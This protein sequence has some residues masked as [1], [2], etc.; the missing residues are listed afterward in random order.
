MTNLERNSIRR[1]NLSK[2]LPS[3]PLL[4]TKDIPPPSEFMLGN[5]LNDRIDANETSQKILHTYSDSSYCK[6]SKIIERFPKS[7]RNEN[8]GYNSSSQTRG[9]KNLQKQ[10]QE[11][12]QSQYHK[13][14]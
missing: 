7:P 13:K 5:N 14:N 4:L 1:Q 6:N 3:K 8:K 2:T 12:Q 10:Q 11:D 9:Y